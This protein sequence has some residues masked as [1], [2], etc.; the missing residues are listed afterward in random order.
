LFARSTAGRRIRLRTFDSE[1]RLPFEVAKTR[2]PGPPDTS[3][4]SWSRSAPRTLIFRA[5]AS[6]FVPS[7]VKPGLGQVDVAPFEVERLADAE[8]SEDQCRQQWAPVG[9]RS[10][11]P[12]EVARRVEKRRDLLWA[13]EI[14]PSRA[15]GLEPPSASLGGVAGDV[16]VLD[17]NV[18]D[19]RHRAD[20]LV[21][22]GR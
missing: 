7:H 18:K 17:G 8:A 15:A 13:V 19:R 3:A 11:L 6:V 22:R 9:P 21:D 16:L 2:S 12:I 4:S 20:H 1:S 10:P 14:G 5:A